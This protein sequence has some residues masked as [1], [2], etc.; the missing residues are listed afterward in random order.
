MNGSEQP[1]NAKFVENVDKIVKDSPLERFFKDKRNY[2]QDLARKATELEKDSTTSLGCKD[3]LPKTINVSLHQQVIYCDDSSS[4]KRDRRWVAQEELVKRIAKITTRIL[5]EGEGV[6]LRFIN[7]T[8]DESPNLTLEDIG[9]IFYRTSWDPNGDTPIGT[10]L[11]SKILQ[12]LVYSTLGQESLKRPLLISVITDGMPSKENKT[13]FVDAIVECGRK[14]QAAGYPRESVKFM[15]GQ[16]GTAQAATKFL[17]GIRTNT[18][19]AKVV[20]VT[21]DQ[22]DVKFADLH[23]NEKV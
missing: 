4:M 5:P 15:V 12:P 14:L 3:V 20:Y 19:I 18:D 17:D 2:I 11:R 16:I 6:A 9:N 1:T 7:K 13:E 22:L 21:S 23:E 8:V 10:F